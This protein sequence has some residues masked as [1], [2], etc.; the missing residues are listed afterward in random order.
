LFTITQAR[1]RTFYLSLPIP[2]DLHSTADFD[3]TMEKHRRVL[4]G[5][6]PGDKHTILSGIFIER[7]KRVP[8]IKMLQKSL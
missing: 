4:T 6:K 2:N 3:V 8:K 7:C 5:E 1:T